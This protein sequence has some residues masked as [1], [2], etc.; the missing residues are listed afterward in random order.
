[1]SARCW[2]KLAS[3]IFI[4]QLSAINFHISRFYSV[5]FGRLEGGR[6][7]GS[8]RG[9]VGDGRFIGSILGTEPDGRGIGVGVSS[10]SGVAEGDGEGEELGFGDGVGDFTL[11]FEFVVV[12]ALNKLFEPL[13][14]KFESNPRFV[15]MF[16]FAFALFALAFMLPLSESPR[17]IAQKPSA[18]TTNN[19]SVPNIV[20]K[21]ILTVFDFG[22][23]C[24]GIT[25][26]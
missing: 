11:A 20:R 14:L 1:M 23:C 15:L 16:T 9:G 18:P 21:T 7:A 24:G 8:I 12:F 19:A 13:K 22:C 2:S 3:G 4:Y 10:S 5:L 6:L 25:R 17:D 26:A